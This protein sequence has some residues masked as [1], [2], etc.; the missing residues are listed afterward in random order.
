MAEDN[1][2]GLSELTEKSASAASAIQ[3]AV[4]TGKAIAAASKG[5][6][7]GGPYGAVAGALWANRKHLGKIIIVATAITLIPILFLLML[8][9]MVF[10][11]V[12]AFF[13]GLFGGG[14]PDMVMND[15][16]AIYE[17]VNEISY[18]VTSILIE[19]IDDV[20]ARINSEFASSGCDGLEIINPYDANLVYNCNL[21]VSQYCAAKDKD[22]ESIKLSDMASVLRTGKDKLYSYTSR[23]ELRVRTEV[24]PETEEETRITEN[25]V[26]YTIAYNGEHYFADTIFHLTGE[27]K[28][29]AQNYAQNMSLFMDD[30]MYQHLT[31]SEYII[32]PS[33]EGIVFTD[34]QTQVVYYNQLDSRWATVMYGTSGTIGQGGC[35]PTS[36]AIV[37]S[38]LTGQAHDPV[39]LANWSVANGH[40]CEGNGSYHSLI[41]ESAKA[42]GLAV[43][44]A[45]VNDA[46]KIADALASG[47]LVVALM[48]K[49]HFTSGGHYIVL[50]GVTA[51]GKI[52]VADPASY[53]RSEKQWELSLI[54]NE[55]R[56]GAGAGGP[57]WIIG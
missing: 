49:G 54:L 45:G 4:K 26:I 43:E 56:R 23:T 21:F 39:E 15:N 52:L 6:A 34:G 44:G 16:I 19:G 35:G 12:G 10:N 28:V 32:G 14:T 37:I 24:D 13:G 9:L 41:P 22:F 55:A 20:T 53:S 38:T 17:N 25:W 2:S 51:D 1:K 5:A 57:F 7:V 40:R 33:Y 30:G 11:T 29:L 8:P 46:Q 31:S 50:R 27:Q 3:G 18:T 48:S 36:M 47:K 42:Y